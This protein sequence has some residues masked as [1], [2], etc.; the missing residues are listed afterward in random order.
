MISTMIPAIAAVGGTAVYDS[1]RRKNLSI[2]EKIS[3]STSCL[4]LTSL[5]V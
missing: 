4:A 5:A 2:R 1:R 3:M